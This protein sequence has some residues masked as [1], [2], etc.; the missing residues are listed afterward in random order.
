MIFLGYFRIRNHFIFI[1]EDDR[2][3]FF[4]FAGYPAEM[5]R[6]LSCNAGLRRRITHHFRFADYIVE[7][8][9]KIF[10]IKCKDVSLGLA[11]D[12]TRKMCPAIKRTSSLN[13]PSNKNP[14]AFALTEIAG[15]TRMSYIIDRMESDED[16]IDIIAS[17]DIQPALLVN[18]ARLQ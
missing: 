8:L 2:P 16:N 11:D 7:E 12:R 15:I 18:P 14:G 6:F 13:I 10:I 4:I 17:A 9:S 5:D 3:A 1:S